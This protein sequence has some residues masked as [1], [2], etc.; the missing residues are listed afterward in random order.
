VADRVDKTYAA[1]G[2]YKT[3]G[4]RSLKLVA[5]R[6]PKSKPTLDVEVDLAATTF[7]ERNGATTQHFTG[8]PAHFQVALEAFRQSWLVT[9]FVQVAS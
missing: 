8:G 5:R 4:V 9:S 6:G 1:G 7:V 3:R 2:Y